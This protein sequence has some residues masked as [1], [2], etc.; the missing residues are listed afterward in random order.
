M[1]LVQSSL[2][3]GRMVRGEEAK[4]CSA[5]LLRLLLLARRPEHAG[6]TQKNQNGT[7]LC[8]YTYSYALYVQYELVLDLFLFSSLPS[9][10]QLAFAFPS[11]SKIF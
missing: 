4:V 5:S 7:V 3:A 10:A 1:P 9:E 2:F 6:L 11:F 8:R